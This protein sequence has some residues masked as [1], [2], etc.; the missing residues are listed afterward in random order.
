[1]AELHPACAGLSFLLG[2]WQGN[3]SGTYP[4]IDPFNYTEEVV[5]SHS[6]KPFLEYSQK[7]RDTETGQPLHAEFGYWRPT[8]NSKLEVV[9]VHPTGIAEV[10]QGQITTKD[11]GA[12]NT[13]NTM[14]IHLRSTSVGLSDTAKPVKSLDRV[15]NFELG[16]SGT[17]QTAGADAVAGAT[18]LIYTLDMSFADIPLQRH[19]KGTLLR[20]CC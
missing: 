17:N 16:H 2:R 1:M 15:F 20:E 3:G 5:F 12:Q 14:R 18:K 8:G 7:T 11:T 9:L 10:S 6:G 13:Q 4:D 19:L